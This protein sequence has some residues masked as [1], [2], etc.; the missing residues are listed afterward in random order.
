MVYLVTICHNYII[1]VH[2]NLHFIIVDI[3]FNLIPL[4]KG[5]CCQLNTEIMFD[6]RADTESSEE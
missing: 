3:P 1:I 5:M 4:Y 2:C 6:Y